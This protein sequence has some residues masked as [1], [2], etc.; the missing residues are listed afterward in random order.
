MLIKDSDHLA[1]T[2]LLQC[3]VFQFFIGCKSLQ[4]WLCDSSDNNTRVD[5]KSYSDLKI[6][7][8]CRV[9]FPIW[10]PVTAKSIPMCDSVRIFKCN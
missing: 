5:C 2:M 10:N 3:V 9:I 6:S 8:L 4:L 1:A 7:F